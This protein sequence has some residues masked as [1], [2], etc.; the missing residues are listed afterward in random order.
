MREMEKLVITPD[1]WPYE[2]DTSVWKTP[3]GKKWL[4]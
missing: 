3:D 1:V 4:C 2:A